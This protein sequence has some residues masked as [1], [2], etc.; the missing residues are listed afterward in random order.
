MEKQDYNSIEGKAIL[1]EVLNKKLQDG[2]KHILYS[3]EAVED[4][5]KYHKLFF[6]LEQELT[7]IS[8]FY[9]LY[10]VEKV[11]IDF[12]KD[13]ATQVTLTREK[14]KGLSYARLSSF[15]INFYEAIISRGMYIYRVKLQYGEQPTISVGEHPDRRQTCCDL[16]QY[17]KS[18]DY[19]IQLQQATVATTF[20]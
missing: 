17:P 5:D 9:T 1:E 18:K 15:M 4:P 12:E 16:K 3:P 10:W 14:P 20:I 19:A 11:E 8:K 6:F 13:M 7:S 2:M